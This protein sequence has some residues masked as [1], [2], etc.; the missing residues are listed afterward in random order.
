[1]EIIEIKGED[2]VCD[3]LLHLAQSLLQNLSFRFQL[4]PL[5]LQEIAARLGLIIFVR[6]YP[7]MVLG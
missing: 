4:P 5:D 6:L 2:D 7:G 3:H 1:L